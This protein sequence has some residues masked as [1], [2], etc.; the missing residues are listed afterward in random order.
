MPQFFDAIYEVN[1][2]AKIATLGDVKS[3]EG[4]YGSLTASILDKI[5]VGGN[6]L[7]P[8]HV[9]EE[10]PATVQ[11]N[12]RTQDLFD[13]IIIEGYYTKGNLTKMSDTFTFD[14]NS[15][16]VMR[17][18]YKISPILVTGI[19]YRW[20]WTEQENGSYKADNTVMPYMALRFQF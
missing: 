20:S 13:K 12:L 4:I 5:M 2:D 17:F 6:L 10:S 14:E 11:L 16:A 1:K 15:L 9:S 19:D 8:D 3:Q 7:L 18:A